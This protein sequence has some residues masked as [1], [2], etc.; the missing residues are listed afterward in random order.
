MSSQEFAIEQPEPQRRGRR[1][2]EAEIR[3]PRLDDVGLPKVDMTPLKSAAEQVLLTG[4]GIGIL[5]GRGRKFDG[6]YGIPAA[7][8]GT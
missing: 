7:E 4:I 5:V 2:V 8:A 1:V 6:A 3:M